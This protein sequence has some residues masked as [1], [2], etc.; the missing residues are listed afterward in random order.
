[1]SGHEAPH[2]VLASAIQAHDEA[3][4][5][6]HDPKLIRKDLFKVRPVEHPCL[7]LERYICGLT[8]RA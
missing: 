6:T 7:D 2:I 3:S 5:L 1:M 4:L 8:A